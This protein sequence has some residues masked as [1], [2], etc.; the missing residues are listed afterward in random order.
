[1]TFQLI[2]VGGAAPVKHLFIKFS[3]KNRKNEETVTRSCYLYYIY[4]YI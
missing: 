4:V 1:M 2:P 3:T